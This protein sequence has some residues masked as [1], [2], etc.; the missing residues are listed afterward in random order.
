VKAIKEED[1]SLLPDSKEE[2]VF[3]KKGGKGLAKGKKEVGGGHG[4]K[5]LGLLE[6]EGRQKGRGGEKNRDLGKAGN[7]L[8]G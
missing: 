5:N 8:G 1:K 7:R 6:E 2:R 4:N 3:V